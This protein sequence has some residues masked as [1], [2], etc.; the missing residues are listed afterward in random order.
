[1]SL[2]SQESRAQTKALLTGLVVPTLLMAS[3][4][5]SAR[6]TFTPEPASAKASES[7]VASAP[8]VSAPVVSAPVAPTPA[9]LAPAALAPV[10]RAAVAPTPVASTPVAS[11]PVA[12]VRAVVLTHGAAEPVTACTAGS[13]YG[14]SDDG[15]REFFWALVEGQGSDNRQTIGTTDERAQR[16]ISRALR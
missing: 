16:M 5:I 9:A 12:S 11:A 14:H 13:S 7:P 15:D 3:F 4:V 1:M 2:R 6:T 10:T 8:V